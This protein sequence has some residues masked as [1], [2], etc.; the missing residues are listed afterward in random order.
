MVRQFNLE[1][2]KRFEKSIIKEDIEMVN[3]YMK[4]CSISVVIW[5]MQIKTRM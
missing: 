1:M 3:K 5:K 4:K 2:G